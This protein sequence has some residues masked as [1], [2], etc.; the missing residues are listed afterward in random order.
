MRSPASSCAGGYDVFAREDVDTGGHLVHSTEEFPEIHARVVWP[1][2]VD[3]LDDTR[4]TFMEVV[5]EGDGGFHAS[6]IR[7]HFR[8]ME[9]NDG[10]RGVERGGQ[11]D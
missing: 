11:V 6:G 7:Q 10:R 2:I 5:E 9:V 8:P 3:G 1:Q 4:V